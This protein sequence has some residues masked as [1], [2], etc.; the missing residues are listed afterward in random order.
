MLKQLL[1][2][3]GRYRHH[4]EFGGYLSNH[5]LHGL[6]ALAG[7][8]ATD[9]RLQEFTTDYV[10]YLEPCA[11]APR[12]PVDKSTW[13]ELRGKQ[14][15]FIELAEFFDAEQK[16]IGDT[17]VCSASRQSNHVTR[18]FYVNICHLF[19]TECLDLRYMVS[20]N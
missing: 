3:H 11:E 15:R 4:I 13:L 20:F 17:K 1:E 8:G 10:R 2:T 5:L 16:R 18:R 19:W 9:E 7:L 6:V 14:C 12:Q